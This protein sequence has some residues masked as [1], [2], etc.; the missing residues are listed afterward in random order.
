MNISV[1]SFVAK[2]E[3]NVSQLKRRKNVLMYFRIHYQ[4]SIEQGFESLM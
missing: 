1:N 3:S 4:I 2:N